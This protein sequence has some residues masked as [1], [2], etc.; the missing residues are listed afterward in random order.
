MLEPYPI[1]AAPARAEIRV[2]N[3]RF[4]G[5]AACTPSVEAAR[6]FIDEMRQLFAGARHHAYAYVV[7]YGASV[8]EGMSDDGEPPGTAGR[9]MLAIVRGSGLGDVTVVV[10]R[11]FGGTL[12]GT[13]G[14]VHAYGDA[15]RAV[16]EVLPRTERIVQQQLVIEVAYAQYQRARQVLDAHQATI[17]DEVFAVT[18]TLTVLLPQQQVAACCAALAPLHAVVSETAPA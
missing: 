13:G 6:A 10:T 12:L 18:V 8:T 15:T 4:I 7:G 5:S 1:P 11:F 2:V 3:S 17:I 14:L 9:P 16:L